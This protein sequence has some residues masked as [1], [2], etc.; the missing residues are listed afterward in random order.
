M[1]SPILYFDYISKILLPFTRYYLI[2]MCPISRSLRAGDDDYYGFK[3]VEVAI[4]GLELGL[5]KFN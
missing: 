3:E 1:I 5:G 4:L 2:P